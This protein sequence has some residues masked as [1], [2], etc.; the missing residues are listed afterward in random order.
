MRPRWTEAPNGPDFE[1]PESIGTPSHMIEPLAFAR[2]AQALLTAWADTEAQRVAR[3]F[4]VTKDAPVARMFPPR[5]LA[6][7][8]PGVPA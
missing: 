4:L 3:P 7:W 8:A 6:Q 2:W 5:W 1:R